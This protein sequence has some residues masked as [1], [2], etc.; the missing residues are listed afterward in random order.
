MSIDHNDYHWFAPAVIKEAEQAVADF[1]AEYAHCN[2]PA[3]WADGMVHVALRVTVPW[4]K[5]IVATNRLLGLVKTVW[6]LPE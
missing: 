4:G 6:G 5:P 1:V 2:P 3:T